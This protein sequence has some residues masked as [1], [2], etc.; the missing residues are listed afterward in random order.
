MNEMQNK[1]DLPSDELNLSFRSY[2]GLSDAGLHTVGDLVKLSPMDI[3]N[4]KKVNYSVIN[5][6][7]FSRRILNFKS[8]KEIEKLLG[9]MG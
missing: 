4:I 8:L 7:G 1:H 2:R 5:D 6:R 3:L 9:S